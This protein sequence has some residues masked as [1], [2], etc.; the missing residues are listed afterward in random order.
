M[1]SLA[2]LVH[3]V[4]QTNEIDQTNQTT[5]FLN[6]LLDFATTQAASADPDA[7]CLA[8]DQCANWL[9]VRFEGP[10]GLVV[11]MTDV[12]AGLATFATEIACKCHGSTPSTSRIDASSRGVKC[13][14]GLFVLTSSFG[15]RGWRG[16]SAIELA[17]G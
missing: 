2:D 3:L 10:F 6:R 17:S 11:G 16:P 12:M 1:F 14:T 5:V 15:G 4:N 8:V 13:I 7:L 9:Q